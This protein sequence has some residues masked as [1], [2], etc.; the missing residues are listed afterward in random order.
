MEKLAEYIKNHELVEFKFI[1]D[2]TGVKLLNDGVNWKCVFSRSIKD[3]HT[4]G[5]C[6]KT[7]EELVD[8]I[9]NERD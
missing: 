4:I 8:N 7:F 3:N 5:Y 9:I 1:Y 6:G 2:P